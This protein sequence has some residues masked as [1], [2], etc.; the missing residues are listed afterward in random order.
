MAK[1]YGITKAKHR[2]TAFDGEGAGIYPGRWNRAGTSMVYTASHLSLAVLEIMAHLGSEKL[3][4]EK[5]VYFELDIDGALIKS[6]PKGGLPSNWK[7]YPAP[8]STQ[9]F[10]DK[11][12][13]TNDT[14]VLKVPSVIVDIESNLLLNPLHPLFSEVKISAARKFDF[15]TRILP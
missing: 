3:V 10:G 5:Y 1:A 7:E 2:L 6:P 4:R 15:D 14:P 9:K 12:V 11:W 13:A 8:S